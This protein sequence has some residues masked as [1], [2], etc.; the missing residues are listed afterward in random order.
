MSKPHQ[1]DLQA[2][3]EADART[4]ALSYDEEVSRFGVADR[5]DDPEDPSWFY[6]GDEDEGPADAWDEDED[7]RPAPA[8]PGVDFN[9]MPF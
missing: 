3:W 7:D 4:E 8:D 6:D 5:W 1:S 9:D 2:R